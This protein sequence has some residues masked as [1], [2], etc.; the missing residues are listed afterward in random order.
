MKQT[1]YLHEGLGNLPKPL[2]SGT[3]ISGGVPYHEAKSE[4][5]RGVQMG[6]H[7]FSDLVSGDSNVLGKQFGRPIQGNLSNGQSVLNDRVSRQLLRD[8]VKV[9]LSLDVGPN[10]RFPS[11][12]NGNLTLA[13]S[14]ASK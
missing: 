13:N 4:I 3:C 14:S 11:Q 9:N 2:S 5:F 7:I 6:N 1:F 8:R 12:H 10:S